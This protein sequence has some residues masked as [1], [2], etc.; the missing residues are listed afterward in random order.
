MKPSQ[1]TLALPLALAALT[2]S[3]FAQTEPAAPADPAT[4]DGSGLLG[5][6]YVEAGAMIADY[7]NADDDGYSAATT[8]NLPVRAFLDVGATFEHSWLEGDQGE[9]FQDLSVFAT[10][11]AQ[12]G[13]F[14][15]FARAEFG[16]EWWHVSDDA[17]YQLDAGSEYLL[18]DRLS[19]SAQISWGEYLAEDWN[20]G[21]FSAS[22]RANYWLTESLAASAIVG[23]TEGGNWNYGL[24]AVFAF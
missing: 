1:A 9:N 23:C 8:V 15:P 7:N 16:Y 14:R 5:K 13:A 18:N 22:A 10:A 11:Y 20:G 3:A 2:T 12:R 19:L 4:A 24:A 6:R 21:A 17:F